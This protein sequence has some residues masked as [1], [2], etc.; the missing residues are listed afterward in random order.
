MSFDTKI[1]K[2]ITSKVNDLFAVKR[3]SSNEKKDIKK[4][5][6]IRFDGESSLVDKR[7]EISNLD[8]LRDLAEMVDVIVMLNPS[9]S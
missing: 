2:N 8:L 1:R 5:L 9:N 7:F 6:L 3:S 4:G